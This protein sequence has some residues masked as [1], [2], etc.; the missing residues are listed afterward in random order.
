VPP[1]RGKLVHIGSRA[2]SPPP[3]RSELI[4]PCIR[5]GALLC[6]AILSIHAAY[7]ALTFTRASAVFAMIC[8][9]VDSL[10]I[11]IALQLA[12]IQ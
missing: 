3:P 6:V 12:T 4:N 7:V 1:V 2:P 5:F 11:G 9:F 10:V 8:C